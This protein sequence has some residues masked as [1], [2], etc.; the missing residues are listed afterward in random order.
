MKII[1]IPLENHQRRTVFFRVPWCR[2]V[3][4]VV[5]ALVARGIRAQPPVALRQLDPGFALLQFGGLPL[6][7]G[8][9]RVQ[10]PD[11]VALPPDRPP[12]QHAERHDAGSGAATRYHRP[13]PAEFLQDAA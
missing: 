8:D 7:L 1:L 11:L 6:E 9:V 13:L 2:P 4:F 3:A 12:P 10:P 5:S